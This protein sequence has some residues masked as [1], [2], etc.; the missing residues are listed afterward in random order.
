MFIPVVLV[1][2]VVVLYL[3][4]WP[5]PIKPVKW[6][7]PKAPKL[8]GAYAKN[9]ALAS[10][11]R[12]PVGGI[13]PEDVIFDQKGRLFTGLEDGRIMGMQPD[14]QD[15]K[16]LAHTGGRPLG[17]A[18]DRAGNLIVADS[19]QGL[20]S[21]NPQGEITTLCD[22]F[23]GRKLILTNHLDVAANGMIY[24]SESSDLFPL[25]N[26]VDDFLDGRPNGR[27]LAYDPRDKQTRL[28]LDNL[29]F[30]NGVAISPDQSFLLV[31]EGGRYRLQRLWLS[32]P[33]AGESELFIENLPGF[34]DNLH[35]NGKDI[36]WL[37]LVSPRK[38]IA[39]W[40]ASRPFFRKVVY[41]LPASLKPAPDQFGF[42]LGLDESGQ[43]IHNFQDPAGGFGETSCAK[44]F[45]GHLYLGC[46]S[47]D[48]IGRLHVPS[49]NFT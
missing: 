16:Q 12:I 30:A 44:E 4:F 41:R 2:L 18:V 15:L 43:I 31:A 45:Q 32:G 24:F 22:R 8:E 47:G 25:S 38:A 49:K 9:L 21:V 40:L 11:D 7:P 23:E 33:R 42:I 29:H 13:G 6:V 28:A 3:L 37:G 36:F 46:L 14:G 39:E 27:L 17:L 1:F 10:I 19:E 48:A 34:P 35:S 26:Y 20:L 5:V